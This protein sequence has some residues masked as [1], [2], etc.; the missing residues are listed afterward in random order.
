MRGRPDP[1]FE[2]GNVGFGVLQAGERDCR[3]TKLNFATAS[4][5]ICFNGDFHCKPFAVEVAEGSALFR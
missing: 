3:F 5:L 2:L 4:L 1:L